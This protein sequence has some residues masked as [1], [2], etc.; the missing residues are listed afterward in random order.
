MAR[1]F[2]FPYGEGAFFVVPDGLRVES[3]AE[4][5][6][7][8]LAEVK[9]VRV[10]RK[11]ALPWAWIVAGGATVLFG[12]GIGEFVSMGVAGAALFWWLLGCSV[13][14]ALVPRRLMVNVQRTGFSW[15]FELTPVLDLSWREGTALWKEQ[16]PD[17]VQGQLPFVEFFLEELAVTLSKRRAREAVGLAAEDPRAEDG[18]ALRQGISSK[19][20]LYSWVLPATVVFLVGSMFLPRVGPLW[21]MLLLAGMAMLFLVLSLIGLSMGASQARIQLRR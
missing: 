19:L 13:V 9:S 15:S 2:R 18:I 6:F 4:S 16:R 8:P 17:L 5:V 7:V 11:R 10:E 20:L 3:G 12:A 1:E 21:G 14:V